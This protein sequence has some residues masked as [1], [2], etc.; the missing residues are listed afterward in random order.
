M[1]YPRD[2]AGQG[3]EWR[4]VVCVSI[5]QLSISANDSPEARVGKSDDPTMDMSTDDGRGRWAEVG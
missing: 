3:H 4:R 2:A 1:H 5:S